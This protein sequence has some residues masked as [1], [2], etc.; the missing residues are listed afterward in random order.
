MPKYE[1]RAVRVFYG[2]PRDQ[3]GDTNNRKRNDS[4]Q[5]LRWYE[6]ADSG[7]SEPLWLLDEVGD[8]YGGFRDRG[9]A[10]FVDYLNSLGIDGWKLV[11]YTRHTGFQGATE[12]WPRGAYLFMREQ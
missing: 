6:V 3:W 9:N 7:R 1:Y 2:G 11:S 8:D 4:K 12:V 5:A 10:A